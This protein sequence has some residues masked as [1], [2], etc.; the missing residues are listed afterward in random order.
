M[1]T[2]DRRPFR[3]G[4]LTLPRVFG[5]NGEVGIPGTPRLS[6][7]TGNPEVIGSSVGLVP[8]NS[9]ITSNQ[10]SAS[11]RVRQIGSYP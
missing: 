10:A 11:S 6:R 5:K 1:V 8:T 7:V 2:A 4:S 3:L 9:L